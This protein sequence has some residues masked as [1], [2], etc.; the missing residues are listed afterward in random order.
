MVDIENIARIRWGCRRGMLELDILLQPFFDARFT[1][2]TVSQQTA[3]INFLEATD[4]ELYAWLMGYEQPSEP[5]FKE[6]VQL[7]K[8]YATTQA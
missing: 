8:S 5:A 1:S 7:I 2:L 6:L 4:P 3:F